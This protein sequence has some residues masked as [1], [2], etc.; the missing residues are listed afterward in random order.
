MNKHILI[1]G[2]TK[3]I[4]RACAEHF[5]ASGWTVTAVARTAADLAAMNSEW[6]RSFPGSLLY[7]VA[8][9]L[10]QPSGIALVPQAPYDV[11]L[12]NAAVFS[13]GT[14]LGGDSIFEDLLGLNV[15]GNQRL[16]RRLLPAMVNRGSGH[17]IVIGS[18]GTDNWK[19]HMT[20]YVATKYALRGL[21]L[22]W[23][24]D[25]TDSGVLTTLIAP[26]ATLTAS[27][28][29]ETPP[30]D[31]LSPARVAAVVAAAVANGTTGRITVS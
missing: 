21:F 2:A 28:V 24:Q 22:G 20:A 31:I 18:T 11:V 19:P 9:D 30:P 4:G 23:E 6:A 7:T 8:A 14:L 3:G 10:G 1:T 15:L 26:G 25:L 29:N 27:W 5:A 12:L 16:A 13:P 17:L